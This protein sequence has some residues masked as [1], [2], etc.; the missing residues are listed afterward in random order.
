MAKNEKIEGEGR[1]LADFDALQASQEEGIDV[2]I[3]GPD[4]KP[5][6]FSIRIAGPDSERQ[7]QASEDIVNERLNSGDASPATAS[8]LMSARIRGLAKSTISW[9]PFKLDGGEYKYSEDAAR[10]LYLRF[11]WMREQVEAKA[12]K[13]AAFLKPSAAPASE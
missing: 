1:D 12:G 11:P 8:D 7:K 9:T 5:L 2:A 3:N 4:G 10:R 13:R 6:G